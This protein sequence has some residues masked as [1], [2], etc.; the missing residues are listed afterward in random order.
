MHHKYKR[1]ILKVMK[2]L[3]SKYM[4]KYLDSWITKDPLN[5]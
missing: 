4:R 2:L 1:K 3:D 5:N